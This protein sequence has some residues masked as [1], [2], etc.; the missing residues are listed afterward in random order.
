[1]VYHKFS[2]EKTNMIELLYIELWE[3]CRLSIRKKWDG[4]STVCSV[5]GLLEVGCTQLR[6]M[7]WNELISRLIEEVGSIPVLCL[8]FKFLVEVGWANEVLMGLRKPLNSLLL[9]PT[10]HPPYPQAPSTGACRVRSR[11]RPNA[12]PWALAVSTTTTPCHLLHPRHRATPSA[13]TLRAG[14]PLC[15]LCRV[16]LLMPHHL[17]EVCRASHESF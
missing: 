1:M 8:V 4:S 17:Q 14:S 6:E 5:L 15:S 9:P 13:P 16:T 10:G 7:G 2:C 3:R 11:A 12:M